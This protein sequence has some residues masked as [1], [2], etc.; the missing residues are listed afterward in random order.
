MAKIVKYPH[1][2][3]RFPAEPVRI[4]DKQVRQ[5][6]EELRALM[7][8]QRGLG[9]AA[10]QIGLPLQIFAMNR[11]GDPQQPDHDQIFINPLIS[12]KKGSVEAEE[13]CLSF[14]EL[15]QKVRR[16]KSIRVQ[17]TNAAGEMVDLH[18]QD[19]E[20]RI[21]QHETDH[22]HGRLFIDY[23]SPL[24]KMDSRERLAYLEREFKK[25]Q[26]KKDLPPTKELQRQL[27]TMA[28]NVAQGASVSPVL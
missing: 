13:G 3:L 21:V 1:P 11:T 18:L 16:A 9:L 23:F 19:L 8:E 7:H 5:I 28:Q 6:I 14:P 15:F 2:A 17:A 25:A 24:A 27:R 4:I 20:A 12:D 26:E 10:P 22:L